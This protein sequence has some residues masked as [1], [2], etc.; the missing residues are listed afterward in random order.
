[1][2]I[3]RLGSLSLD[4]AR[5]LPWHWAKML[6]YA[7]YVKGIYEAAGLDVEKLVAP[8]SFWFD[9]EKMNEWFESR[10]E[11]RRQQ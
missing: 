1:L 11:L 10:E 6:E 8:T 5:N 9:K 3:D 4:E 2:I 7:D